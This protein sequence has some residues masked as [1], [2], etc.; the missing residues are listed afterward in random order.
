MSAERIGPRRSQE[1]GLALVTVLLFIAFLTPL[2]AFALMQARL[3][4]R[5]EDNARTALE[6]FAVAEAGLDHAL[7]DLDL[8]PWFDRLLAGPDGI[9]GNADDKEFPYVH[10]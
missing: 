4:L 5:V 7:A 8:Q 6:T 10:P 1:D 3:D 9:V 2:G